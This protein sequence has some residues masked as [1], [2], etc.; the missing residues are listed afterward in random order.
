MIEER[1]VALIDMKALEKTAADLVVA[2]LGAA[3]WELRDTA[4]LGIQIRDY[5]IVFPDRHEEPLEV[6][7][8]ADPLVLNTMHRM[9][10]K[11]RIPWSG[12][13]SRLR[14]TPRRTPPVRR[15]H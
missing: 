13:R 7:T 3:R 12:E 10:G 8:S 5:D 6:T 14:R 11:N 2:E 9:A 4:G 1:L 15:R